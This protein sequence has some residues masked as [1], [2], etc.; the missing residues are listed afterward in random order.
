MS[1]NLNFEQKVS[2]EAKLTPRITMCS[3]LT[4]NLI[5][6]AILRYKNV[7]E[8]IESFDLKIQ[9]GKTARG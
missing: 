2:D 8:A 3:Q 7:E 6:S 9:Q 1:N 5:P 4:E